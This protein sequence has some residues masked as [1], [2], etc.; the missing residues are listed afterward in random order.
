MAWTRLIRFADESGGI[1]FGEPCITGP[2]ELK[3]L[4]GRGD[5]EAVKLEGT[6]PFQLSRS[7]ERVKVARI[8][9]VLQA[10][11]VPAVKCIGLNY[12]RH[13]KSSG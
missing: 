13:S 8:L 3:T 4:L 6:S 7:D 1:F 9:G 5:L 2:E 11:D 12:V 10:G